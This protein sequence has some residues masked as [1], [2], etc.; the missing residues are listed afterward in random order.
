MYI[1]LEHIPGQEAPL[2]EEP[3]HEAPP[4][5]GVGLLHRLVLI[6]LPVLTLH[7]LQDPQ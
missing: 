6:F 1:E 5:L 2:L 7:E 3:G 4:F